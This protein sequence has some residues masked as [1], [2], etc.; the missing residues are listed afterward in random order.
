MRSSSL[1]LRLEL[2]TEQ[3]AANGEQ[4]G[5]SGYMR[6]EQIVPVCVLCTRICV[7]RVRV[8]VL[9]SNMRFSDITPRGCSHYRM[10][11]STLTPCVRTCRKATQPPIYLA[12]MLTLLHAFLDINANLASTVR[13]GYTYLLGPCMFLQRFHLG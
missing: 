12:G 2:P 1:N 5:T 11:L 9:I 7:G 13:T 4:L 10:R 6:V 3:F 8:H